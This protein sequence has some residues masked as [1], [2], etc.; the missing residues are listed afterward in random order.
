MVEHLDV[1]SSYTL[2]V[3]NVNIQSYN[4]IYKAG[5]KLQLSPIS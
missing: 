1:W 2:C 3:S 4:I 5:Q